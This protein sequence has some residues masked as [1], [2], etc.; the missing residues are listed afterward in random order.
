MLTPEQIADLTRSVE[1]KRARRSV[2]L[3]SDERMA[4]FETLQATAMRLLKSNPAALAAF[5]KRN[6]HRRRE[7][8][9]RLLL[10]ELRS[11]ERE[12]Q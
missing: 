10:A 11:D 5:H 12:R 9:V 3:P 6:H 1:E 7:S 2:A 4:R 8:Q